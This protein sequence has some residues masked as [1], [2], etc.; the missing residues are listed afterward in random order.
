MEGLKTYILSMLCLLIAFSCQ[1]E[2]FP[3]AE[4]VFLYI[5]L[6]ADNITKVGDP[7]VDHGE[8]S[9]S[10]DSIAVFMVQ[11]KNV[12]LNKYAVKDLSTD[13]NGTYYIPLILGQSEIDIY[14]VAYKAPQTFGETYIWAQL[15]NLKTINLNDA[16]F[17]DGEGTLE[18]KR[19]KC[20]MNLFSGRGTVTPSSEKS[21]TIYLTRLVS[22]V[23]VQWDVQDAYDSTTDKFVEVRMSEIAFSGLDFAYFFPNEKNDNETQ[24]LITTG[25]YSCNS[26]IS[27]RN[28]RSYFYTFPEQTVDVNSEKI[29][30]KIEFTLS[31]SYKNEDATIG[32]TDKKY[33]A[34]FKDNLLPAVW[35]KVNINVK[36]MSTSSTDLVIGDTGTP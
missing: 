29:N 2:E 14:A 3:S 17:N 22:K 15:Q 1:K 7:G 16:K 10:I 8:W 12:S 24:N 18:S 11:N 20:M 35:Y 4:E 30:A 31:Y 34:T 32:A 6:P 19:K 5:H 33:T 36:G 13:N 23:D 27:E 25:L 26:A 9:A 28:G 21:V